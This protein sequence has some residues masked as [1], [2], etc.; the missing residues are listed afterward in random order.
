MDSQ[1]FKISIE[2]ITTNKD[3]QYYLYLTNGNNKPKLSVS[4]SNWIDSGYYISKNGTEFQNFSMTLISE[5]EEILEKNGYIYAWIVESKNNSDN[6]REN[7]FILEGY[8]VDRPALYGLG[9][10]IV[11]YFFNDK[12][13]VSN[14]NI[15][16][17][18][19][20]GKRKVKVK[21][22]TIDDSSILNSIK[23]NESG[24]LNKLLTYSKSASSIYTETLPLGT[25]ASII[26]KVGV[27]DGKYYYAYLEL[28]DENGKY[29][30]V[31]DVM[32]YQGKK[33]LGNKLWLCNYGDST[34]TWN[35]VD[36]NT[37]N[38]DNNNNNGN[39]NNNNN[40]GNNNSTNTPQDSTIK[41]G[42][43]PQ[44][45]ATPI[46]ITAVIATIGVAG[47]AVYKMK[48]LKDVK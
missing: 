16:G 9:K 31:E 40:N 10:R 44:T 47:F 12:S 32:L 13:Y 45:G 34:F 37:N 39:N 33:D 38:G 5:G 20:Q 35:N 29:Y 2:G 21:I 25:S 17:T 22:G 27:V 1:N 4:S 14:H 7:Q 3:S 42:K 18:N 15:N 41:P 23:N 6:K 24:A 8:K 36:N 19:S 30:P 26:D 46:F 28:D 11:A 43:L 48:K